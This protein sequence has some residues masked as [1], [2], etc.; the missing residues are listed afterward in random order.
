[1]QVFLYFDFIRFVNCLNLYTRY[2]NT[3]IHMHTGMTIDAKIHHLLNIRVYV[4]VLKLY[5]ISSHDVL[6]NTLCICRHMHA[7]TAY[8]V[9]KRRERER[10][11]KNKLN[12]ASCDFGTVDL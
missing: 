4:F 10:E 2:R 1:M 9:R 8:T 7:I 12:V 6:L 11:E 5:Q 3:E